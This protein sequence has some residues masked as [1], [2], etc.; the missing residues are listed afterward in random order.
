M[1]GGEEMDQSLLAAVGSAIA[2]IFIP[3][4]WGNW[5]AAVASITGLVAKENIVGTMGILYPGG[6]AEIGANF[7]RAAGYSFLVFNLLCAPCFA[8]IGA[9]KREM[10]NA[11][12][13]WFAIGYQCG[14]AYA[15][16]LMVYQMGSAFTG[17][18]HPIGLPAAIV[19]LSCMIYMLFKPY[20][21]ATKLAANMKLK[22]AK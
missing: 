18:L 14:L 6:W 2:W 3:L 12:W 20:K 21:E 7:N 22:T 1:L 11:K 9:I 8:A 10:N 13:T 16:A 19:I 15:V 17:N 4:G 5:Q